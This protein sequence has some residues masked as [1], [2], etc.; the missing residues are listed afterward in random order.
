MPHG[1][2]HGR[3]RSK[4]HRGPFFYEKSAP[5]LII[6]SCIHSSELIDYLSA[7]RL[8]GRSG[9]GRAWALTCAARPPACKHAYRSQGFAGV[10]ASAAGTG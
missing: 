2:T 8:D 10:E 9:R 6:I 7:D 3:V 5:K 4:L 1:V